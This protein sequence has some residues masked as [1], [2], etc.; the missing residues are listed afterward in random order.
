MFL[1]LKEINGAP[2]TIRTCDLRIRR[3]FP[4]PCP[5]CWPPG[6][7]DCAVLVK[8]NL[9]YLA[10]HAQPAYPRPKNGP[11]MSQGPPRQGGAGGRSGVSMAYDASYRWGTLTAQGVKPI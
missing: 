7:T 8:V 6:V 9:G 11:K 4:F 3:T 10:G 1:D 5:F 2:G